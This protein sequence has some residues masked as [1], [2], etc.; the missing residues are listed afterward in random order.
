M[1]QT[2]VD[3]DDDAGTGAGAGG[4]ARPGLARRLRDALLG[5]LLTLGQVLG[6][7]LLARA[8]D[9]LG[10]G[11]SMFP[12]SDVPF[13]ALT[14]VIFWGLPSVMLGQILA[15]LTAWNRPQRRADPRRFTL[16]VACF[17]AV[18][19]VVLLVGGRLFS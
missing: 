16:W 11:S 10:Q 6:A 9:A 8:A 1:S 7:G 15:F 13:S 12:P 17:T 2:I 14:V 18:W 4:D 19:C 3:A 5:V